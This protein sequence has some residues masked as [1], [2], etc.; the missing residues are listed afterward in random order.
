MTALSFDNSLKVHP[1]AMLTRAERS[2]V[3]ANNLANADTPDFKA[4][5]FEFNRVISG[6]IEKRR[7]LA[8][9]RTDDRHLKGRG[10]EGYDLLYRWPSQPAIDGNTVDDNVENAEF[11]KNSMMFNSS[12]EFLNRKF[13]GLRGALRGE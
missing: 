2:E 9:N 1:K 7:S 5:D 3:L 13:T 12:F 11:T 6:E 10:R 4:R 8:V